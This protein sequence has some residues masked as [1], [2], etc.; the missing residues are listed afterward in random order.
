MEKVYGIL[1]MPFLEKLSFLVLI[2]VHY[3]ILIIEK[4]AFLVLGAEPSYGINNSTDA[5]GKKLCKV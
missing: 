4:I 1:V 2:I 3:L 5:A